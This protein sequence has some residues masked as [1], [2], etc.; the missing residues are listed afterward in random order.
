MARNSDCVF[1]KIVSVEIPAAVVYEDEALIGFLDI[2][3]LAS[4]HLLVV[5]REHFTKLTDVPGDVSAKI[6]SMLP[7][8]GK[9]LLEV[10]G[11]NSFNVLNNEGSVAGQAVQHV[12]FHLIPRF[13]G[14]GLGYRWTAGA[15]RE[16]ETVPLVTAYQQAFS[17]PSAVSINA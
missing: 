2:N 17:K 10:T 6:G 5:T 11:A 3:P 4:G 16:G 13:E 7:F 1:C 8:A 14:D 12:H 9:A 15:Y